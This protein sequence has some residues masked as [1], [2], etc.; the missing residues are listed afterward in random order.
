MPVW[1]N[2]GNWRG[3]RA[4]Y[5]VCFSFNLGCKLSLR[6]MQLALEP[7]RQKAITAETILIQK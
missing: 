6:E 2:N 1:K 3:E 7:T 4:D 5:H